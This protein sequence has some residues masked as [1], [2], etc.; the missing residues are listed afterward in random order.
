MVN[1]LDLNGNAKGKMELPQ[2]FSL[3]VRA[4][5]IQRAVL[6]LQAARRQPHGADVFAGKRTAAKY[7]G[8]K[9]EHGSMKN[10]EVARGPRVVGGNPGQEW[11][12][13]FVPHARGGRAAHPPVVEKELVLKINTNENRLALA[14]SIAATALREIVA[15]R[16]H[17]LPD[18]ELPLVL[19]NE[20][21]G[22]KKAKELKELLIRLKLS[23][24]LQRT[25]G[26][27]IRA[28]KGKMRG[29]KYRTKTGPLIVIA[30]DEGV[31]KAAHNI[32]GVSVSTVAELNVEMLA[33]GTQPGRLTIW[34][35]D[36]IRRVGERFG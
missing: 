5:L 33:P 26:H 3:G 20:I 10:R 29:R 24:E 2:V 23:Q 16:G 28:G 7:I 18:T 6:A 9:D 13:R 36:A 1:I 8:M 27:K 12:M 19:T 21:S 22:I 15:A 30:K 17:R 14:S 31:K 4:D 35:E 32:P 25:E 34:S 11:R